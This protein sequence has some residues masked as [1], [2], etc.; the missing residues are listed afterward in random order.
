MCGWFRHRTGMLA[1]S[2]ATGREHL[3]TRLR[4]CRFLCV[5]HCWHC[6]LLCEG[7]ALFVLWRMAALCHMW[8]CQ[9]VN[10]GTHGVQVCR[11]IFLTG[12]SMQHNVGQA[13]EAAAACVAILFRG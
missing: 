12:M 8:H 7:S 11:V 1:S 6:F 3:L 5:L 9:A 4:G 13:L 10:P 2:N